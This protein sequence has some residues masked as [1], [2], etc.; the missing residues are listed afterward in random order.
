VTSNEINF[1]ALAILRKYPSLNAQISLDA[2]FTKPYL[3]HEGTL[4][5]CIVEFMSK[6][7]SQHGLYEIHTVPQS[8]L[9]TEVLKPEQIIELAHLRDFL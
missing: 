2:A 5:E 1:H 9:V 8:T 7:A 6:P 4:D 3:V